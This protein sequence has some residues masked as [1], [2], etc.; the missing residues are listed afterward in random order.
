VNVPADA[1]ILKSSGQIA[2]NGVFV[3]V[4]N[5]A[6][7]GIM[8]NG[9][10][11]LAVSGSEANIN[12]N[13]ATAYVKSGGTVTANGKSATIVHEAGAN[14]TIN[15]TGTQ[16]SCKTITVDSTNAPGNCGGGGG[17]E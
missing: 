4:C 1:M 2:D 11:V 7:A 8:G 9:S 6:T 16:T 3:W 12:G 14:V 10:T 13:S 5:G 17:R 15:G